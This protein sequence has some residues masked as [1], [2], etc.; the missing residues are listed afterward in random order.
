MK[1]YLLIAGLTLSLQ[2]FA[3]SEYMQ[4]SELLCQSFQEG[5]Y[6]CVAKQTAVDN[7]TDVVVLSSKDLVA[8]GAVSFTPK[9]PFNLAMK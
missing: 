6:L 1:H 7:A 2:V 9:V 3:D 5:D 4:T 8:L